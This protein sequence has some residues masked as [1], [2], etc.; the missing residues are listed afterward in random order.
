M[1]EILYEFAALTFFIDETRSFL[2]S[3]TEL[4]WQNGRKN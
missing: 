4:G 1:A 2:M 3:A